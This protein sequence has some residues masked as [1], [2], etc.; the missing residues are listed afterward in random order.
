MDSTR[1]KDWATYASRGTR[2]AGELGQTQEQKETA[3]EL[4]DQLNQEERDAHARILAKLRQDYA[5]ARAEF[6]ETYGAE[7]PTN[8]EVV[9]GPDYPGFRYLSTP[10]IRS[11]EEETP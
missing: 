2:A 1:L 6:R 3:R 10:E 5:E 8:A 9:L 11:V 4:W 7:P